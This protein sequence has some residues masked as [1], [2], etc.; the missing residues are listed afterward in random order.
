M[1]VAAEAADA[2]LREGRSD[3]ARRAAARA[4][5]LHTPGQGTEPPIIDGLDGPAVALTPREAQI[6]ELARQGLTSPQIA[7]RLVLSARTVEAHLY[8][9][10]SKLGVTDRRQL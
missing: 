10:M 3:S 1:E 5:E 2:F 8:R 6:V 7:D 4:G 9:G